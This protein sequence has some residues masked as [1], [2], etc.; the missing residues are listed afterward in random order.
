MSLSEDH[1]WLEFASISEII[2]MRYTHA[3]YAEVSSSAANM[4]NT[5]REPVQ[6]DHMALIRL[7]I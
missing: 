6:S 4:L 7:G 1:R 5:R 3:L 2:S